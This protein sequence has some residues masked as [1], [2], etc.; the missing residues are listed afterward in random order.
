MLDWIKLVSILPERLDAVVEQLGAVA[1]RL[2]AILEVLEVLAYPAAY[3]ALVTW[4]VLCWACG[5]FATNW[6]NRSM[7]GWFFLALLLGP[8]PAFALACASRPKG[9]EVT[10]A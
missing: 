4:L 9:A 5:L 6:R 10:G 7:T 2:E 8:L 3:F 1:G